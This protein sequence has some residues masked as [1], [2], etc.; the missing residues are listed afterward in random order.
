MNKIF[1]LLFLFVVFNTSAQNLKKAFKSFDKGD[2]KTA[3]QLSS[4]IKST[5]K[6]KIPADYL[7]FRSALKLNKKTQQQFI[8]Y[9]SKKLDTKFLL[10]DEND[11]REW[12]KKFG[13]DTEIYKK[14]KSDFLSAL[15]RQILNEKDTELADIYIKSYPQNKNANKISYMRDS[16]TYLQLIKSKTF[17]N[18]AEF[19]EKYPNSSFHKRAKATYDS[20]WWAIYHQFQKEGDLES[21]ELF[22]QKFVRFP[23]IDT[24]KK[25]MLWAE[26]AKE[27]RLQKPYNPEF[28]T[29]YVNYLKTAKTD[30]RIVV[31]QKLMEPALRQKHYL[32][33]FD[34]L[35]H[36]VNYLKDMPELMETARVIKHF[37][38]DVKIQK[39]STLINTKKNEYSPVISADGQTLYFCSLGR[40][41]NLG[42]EDILYSKMHH[43]KWQQVKRLQGINTTYGNEA[44]ESVSA[45]ESTIILFSGNNG[46]D[47]VY[48]QRGKNGWNT[49]KEIPKISSS[50]FEGEASLAAD[51]SVLVFSS[52]RLENKGLFH[53]R[54]RLFH[55]N[56][57]GNTDLYLALK[58]VNGKWDSIIHLNSTI[59]TPYAELSPFLH[60]DMK[61]LYFSSNGHGGLGG[62]EVFK[63]TRLYDTSWVYWSQP[64]SL[65]KEI[66]T[67]GDDWGFKITTDGKLAY[68]ARRENGN[69]DIYTATLPKHVKPNPVVLISGRLPIPVDFNGKTKIYWTDKNRNKIGEFVPQQVDFK[70]YIPAGKYTFYLDTPDYFVPAIDTSI[71]KN[72]IQK[73]YFK[74]VPISTTEKFILKHI[75]FSFNK[76]GLL[77]AS[78][79]E[80]EHLLHFLEQNPGIKIEIDGH[81]DAV[82]D[83]NFNLKLSEKRAKAVQNYL[84]K[85]GIS[86]TRL[87]YKGYGETQLLIHSEKPQA[88]NRRVEFII[89]KK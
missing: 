58:S 30:L 1:S 73:I 5:D 13:C 89:K 49:P 86:D 83:K 8:L 47:L 25:D 61:T 64:V 11:L 82:G 85:K 20:A 55:G 76:A 48:S 15:S 75:Y 67:I 44:P 78:F 74:P 69:F 42:G 59:N 70:F 37:P 77:P 43:G 34:T 7:K 18:Y 53:K 19:M 9:L 2:Y 3:Y 46:G 32:S 16:L 84:I 14:E 38:Q 33:A 29:D 21:L 57:W 26:K 56:L 27:L 40:L 41:E 31:L 45:D 35:A 63:S 52:D 22:R 54:N 71:Q 62:L 51:G 24:L 68:F 66:N 4:S 72:K 88:K 10:A 80:L 39:L 50:Y 79:P 23:F 36:Y 87:S 65:G 17:E 81:T 28:Y 6:S 12:N 60:P